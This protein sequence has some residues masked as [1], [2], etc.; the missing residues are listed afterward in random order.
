M[1]PRAGL[2]PPLESA[3]HAADSWRIRG[4]ADVGDPRVLHRRRRNTS[5]VVTIE[6]EEV[7]SHAVAQN[8]V[9][10]RRGI[11]VG[12]IRAVGSGDVEAAVSR[13]DEPCVDPR[14]GTT[15]GNVLNA[16]LNEVTGRPLQRAQ[17]ETRGPEL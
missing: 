12:P 6:P 8:G 9:A 2:G 14:D 4:D 5:L 3:A 16:F 7:V 15:A 10:R 1:G 11:D 13:R 17:T